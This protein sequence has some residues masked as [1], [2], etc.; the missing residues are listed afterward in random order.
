MEI[1]EKVIT[2]LLIGRIIFSLI[3]VLFLIQGLK[4]IIKHS[5]TISTSEYTIG[6][7]E[8]NFDKQVGIGKIISGLALLLL[9][10]YTGIWFI[11]LPTFLAGTSIQLIYSPKFTYLRVVAPLFVRKEDFIIDPPTPEI[12]TKRKKRVLR[13][14]LISLVIGI[15]GSAILITSSPELKNQSLIDVLSTLLIPLICVSSLLFA[16][17]LRGIQR[18]HYKGNF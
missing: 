9:S 4:L 7:E 1:L 2:I 6:L 15:V 14:M 16:A 17:T 5:R 13:N 18:M 11:F 12:I 10:N 3:G 8:T